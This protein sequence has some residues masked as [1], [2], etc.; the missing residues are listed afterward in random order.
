LP[1]ENLAIVVLSNTDSQ[2]AS[3][4]AIGIVCTLMSRHPDVFA[5]LADRTADESP[6]ALPPELVGSWEG[7]VYPKPSSKSHS[8]S[9]QDQ[10]VP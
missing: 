4:M 8:L 2:W 10:G 9:I 6:F 3:T 7:C 5:L 1:E